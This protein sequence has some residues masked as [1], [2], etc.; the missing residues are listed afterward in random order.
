MP[1]FHTS[2]LQNVLTNESIGMF[3]FHSKNV[4]FHE[5]GE[6]ILKNKLLVI[7]FKVTARESLHH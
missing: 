1:K 7:W 4:F 6:G 5:K 3:Y 2:L